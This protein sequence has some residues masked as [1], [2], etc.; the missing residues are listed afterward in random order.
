[1][2]ATIKMRIT[3]EYE[4]TSDYVFGAI[5]KISKKSL[6]EGET[7]AS[8]AKEIMEIAAK[9]GDD[10]L[11]SEDWKQTMK[12]FN[13]NQHTYFTII[14]RLK[15]AGMLRKSQGKYYVIWDFVDRLGDM[16][17]AM[18]NFYRDIGKTRKEGK[19]RSE[20]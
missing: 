10:G 4:I 17:T 8:I 11:F 1:M 3:P 7:F 20:K 13:I 15:D 14:R 9:K 16:A 19:E 6:V 12:K 5:F 2:A 18:T